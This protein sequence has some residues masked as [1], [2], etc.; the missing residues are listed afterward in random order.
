MSVNSDFL[1]EKLREDFLEC[2][3]GKSSGDVVDDLIKVL[4]RDYILVLKVPLYCRDCFNCHEDMVS[5][6]STPYF[7]MHFQRRVQGGEAN[8]C[9][10]YLGGAE[11]ARKSIAHLHNELTDDL[12][13]K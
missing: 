8:C 2:L 9:K 10:F 5:L 4:K 3:K 6:T 13:Y 7:C 1:E 11:E 12:F